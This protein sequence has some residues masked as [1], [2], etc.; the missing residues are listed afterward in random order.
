MFLTAAVAMIFTQLAGVL[1]SIIDG[2]VTSRAMGEAAYSSISL[3]FPFAG[4][5]QLPATFISTGCQV[6]CSHHVGMGEKKDA[7]AVFSVSVSLGVLVSVLFILACV[8]VPEPL[9]NICGVSVNSHA[10]LYPYMMDYL[11]GYMIGI[12]A[13][14]A[15]HIIGPV[16]VIDNGKSRFT[17]SASVLAAVDI[18]GDILNAYVF[19][20]GTFGMG[21]A[22]SIAFI[23]QLIVLLFHFARK[24][25][26]FA[27]T[28]KPPRLEQLRG[29]SKAGSPALVRKIAIVLRDLL[30]NRIN[31]S[32]A[33]STAAVAAR[34]IQ[35]DLNTLMF[36]IGLGIGKTLLT[37]TGVYFSADDAKGLK[38]LFSYAMKTSFWIAGA[39]GAVLFVF[40][41]PLAA[42][43]TADAEVASL[44]TFAIR[45]MAVGIILDTVTVSFQ[46]YLQG[47]NN[48]KVVSVLTFAERLI[49]PVLTAFVLG[50]LFGSRGIM[51]AI[52]VGK[53]IICVGLFIYICIRKKGFPSR[54][55]DYMLLPKGFGGSR[56][57]NR[58]AQLVTMD[59]VMLESRTAESFCLEHGVAPRTARLISLFV[60]EMAGNIIHH[61][62]ARRGRRAS[63]DYR[64]YINENAIMLSIRDYCQQ[65]DPA[66]YYHAAHDASPGEETGI[67][68]VMRLAK[69]VRYFNAFNSNNL[70]ILMDAD[71]SVGET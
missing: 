24:D 63:V 9:L 28:L 60:E 25:H 53:L 22:T 58:Y 26:Y 8:I 37:M 21:L 34:G 52:A 6:V 4:F 5:V 16:I 45:C 48:R 15:T 69:E 49:I 27:Y 23:A 67:R 62:R 7:N 33:L 43:Y 20:G 35:N 14:I 17:I 44:A 54:W 13:I 29:I 31:L 18:V 3:L 42:F 38:R 46:D 55:E 1:A 71:P 61:G 32:V 65:F 40:A 50:N 41:H 36:C 47:I 64:L 66:A 56:D 2:I 12:P 11:K 68:M 59:D 10:E 30:V 39:S 19:H 57:N 70:I 51:A